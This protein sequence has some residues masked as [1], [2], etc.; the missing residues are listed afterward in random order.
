MKG[1]ARFLIAAACLV[2]LTGATPESSTYEP[3]ADHLFWFLIITDSHIR[4]GLIGDKQETKNLDWATSELVDVVQPEFMVNMGDLV[5]GT[6]GG[7]VPIGQ[8]D[9]EWQNYQTI[10]DGNGMGPDFYYDIPGN[11]D[12]Y[13]DGKLS[14]YQAYSVQ[15]R[16]SG[17]INHSWTL[18]LGGKDYFFA[19]L[20]T[21]GSDGAAWPFDNVSLDAADLE[22]LS[23]ALSQA[24]QADIATFFGHHPAAYM[25]DGKDELYDA[26]AEATATMYAFGHTHDYGKWWQEQTLHLNLP[27]L[28][29]SDH[30]QVGLVAYDGSGLSVTAF[31]V[32]E[33]PQVLVTA[34]LDSGLGGN[35]LY[36]YMVPD[37]LPSA[38]VRA[39]AFHP[40][41]IQ[42]VVATLDGETEIA[43][44]SV[45]E[46]VWQGVFD[47]TDLDEYPHQLK[48]VATAA[49]GDTAAH[50]I[51][52]YVFAS[53]DPPEPVDSVEPY[54]DIMAQPDGGTFEIAPEPFEIVTDDGIRTIE[55][56]GF[57]LAVAADGSALDSV[58]Q[59]VW[60]PTGA[61]GTI[62][63]ESSGACDAG[64]APRTAAA[65]PLL[66]LLLASARLRRRT[67]SRC[68]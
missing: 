52:F 37:N 35:H 6:G 66:L 17:A 42:S 49:G 38:V 55:A 31:D 21:C 54:D 39:L 7:L 47:S 65:I 5:D 16:N 13:F 26:L 48:V 19:A 63:G 43:M 67:T 64:A 23:Q 28:G 24:E 59:E 9:E 29:K 11:H 68:P 25:N 3:D 4:T 1:T 12:Q 61:T 27:S 10:V 34:P 15:G 14:H 22:F 32:G 33:W 44:E 2:L 53:P 20:A 62:P 56:G 60:T 40:D 50:E 45:E 57:D 18:S 46:N 30:F 36:D 8:S 58:G 41:G 51:N